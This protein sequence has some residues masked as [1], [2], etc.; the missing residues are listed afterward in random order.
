MIAR[1]ITAR[2]PHRKGISLAMCLFFRLHCNTSWRSWVWI[3]VKTTPW[4]LI[5]TEGKVLS[6]QWNEHLQNG[7]TIMSSLMLRLFK[8]RLC[9]IVPDVYELGEKRSHRHFNACYICLQG[10]LWNRYSPHFPPLHSNTFA[11]TSLWIQGSEFHKMNAHDLFSFTNWI[12]NNSTP[13]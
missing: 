11:L 10:A 9:L 7:S 1:V 12:L 13:F 2:R 6:L 3:L 4:V 8:P 5:V